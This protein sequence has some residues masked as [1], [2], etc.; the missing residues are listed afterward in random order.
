MEGK[1]R[2]L[3]A[4]LKRNDFN[5]ARKVAM[6]L[7]EPYKTKTLERILIQ[8]IE[9][10]KI[11]EIEKTL[12]CLNRELTEKE[13]KKLSQMKRFSK[14]RKITEK[15]NREFS[16]KRF[17]EI[18][19]RDVEKSWIDNIQEEAEFLQEGIE[20][21]ENLEKIIKEYINRGCLKEAEKTAKLAGR[22]LTSQE[23]EK[24]LSVKVK[25]G[26][27]QEA[28]KIAKILARELTNE[29]LEIILAAQIEEGK[30]EDLKHSIKF[31]KNVSCLSY[32]VND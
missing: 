15:V 6:L 10:G 23:L 29:E 8:C 18:L 21:N 30:I 28:Q 25:N 19:M 7:P 3:S 26:N 16:A 12:Q 4:F 11:E 22:K 24:I 17:Q 32:F 14:E 5:K 13:L 9:E 1:K 31:I 27:F 2:L 20:N